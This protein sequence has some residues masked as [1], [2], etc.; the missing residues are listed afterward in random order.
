MMLAAWEVEMAGARV[1][2]S[3]ML[4]IEH[5]SVQARGHALGG[6]FFFFF[7]IYYLAG[8]SRRGRRHRRSG[9]SCRAATMCECLMIWEIWHM[10]HELRHE[11]AVG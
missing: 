4:S 1:A 11:F 7:S 5:T 6:V 10:R 3:L 2:G 9:F 8:Q